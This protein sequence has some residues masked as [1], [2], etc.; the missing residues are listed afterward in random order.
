MIG[1]GP[2]R[3]MLMKIKPSNCYIL[4]YVSKDYKKELMLAAD[5]FLALNRRSAFDL[6]L[7]EAM[8]A[9]S[10]PVT[11]YMGGNAEAAL[12]AGIVCHYRLADIIKS[13]ERNINNENLEELQMKAYLKYVN[14]FTLDKMAER[15]IN[16]YLSIIQ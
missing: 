5:F 2:L 14:N 10:I 15:Y 1:G 13:I 7:L 12:G 8:S 16:F 6:A 9:G 3:N 11:T 4:G